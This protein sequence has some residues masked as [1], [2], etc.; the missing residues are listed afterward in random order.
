MKVNKR[1]KGKVVG[2]QKKDL[3]EK[4]F[5]GKTGRRRKMGVLS[6][7]PWQEIRVVSSGLGGCIKFEYCILS[8]FGHNLFWPKKNI[9]DLLSFFGPAVIFF[10]ACL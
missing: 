10:I 8:I 6:V 7:C 9:S 1:S 5:R 2:I 4:L 3:R